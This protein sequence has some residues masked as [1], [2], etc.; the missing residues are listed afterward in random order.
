MP[1]LKDLWVGM[2][3]RDI[4]DAG[5]NSNVFLTVI[6]DNIER[7]RHTFPQPHPKDLGKG[8]ANLFSVRV[9]A[10]DIVSES[11]TSNSINVRIGGDD[12]WSPRHIV[13]WGRSNGGA[14]IPL[15]IRT[16]ITEKISGG[17]NEGKNFLQIPLVASGNAD[18]QINRLLMLMLTAD[19]PDAGT[20][21]QISLQVFNGDR[22]VAEFD[23]E[24]T[25]QGDQERGRAALY[26]APVRSS[27]TKR[28]LGARSIKLKIR[29]NDA[30]TPSQFFLFGLDDASGRPESLVPLV[31][32][33]TWK[34]GLPSLSLDDGEGRDFV[35]LPLA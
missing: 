15:A 8:Q 32:I 19:V 3:T 7:L 16:D 26:F 35:D 4:E 6:T 25:S 10:N 9:A 18:L 33:P 34:P 30:W 14:V 11:L 21:N 29:G 28:S 22:L 31:H 20:P 17:K 1:Q 13:V 5:T 27:F 24:A 12:Q 2:E 23:S